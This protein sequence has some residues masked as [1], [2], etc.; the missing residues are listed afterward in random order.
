MVYLSVIALRTIYAFVCFYSIKNIDYDSL[1]CSQILHEDVHD[2][3]VEKLT[4][5]YMQVR[6]GDPLDG[7]FF[8]VF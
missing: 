3:I 1:F 4:K 6:V 7:K 2:E 5:A 8:I